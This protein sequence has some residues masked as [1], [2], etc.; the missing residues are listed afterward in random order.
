MEISVLS[1]EER[2]QLK[3]NLILKQKLHKS[4]RL[5]KHKEKRKLSNNCE[6][7]NQSEEKKRR[8]IQSPSKE[9]VH[10]PLAQN[11]VEKKEEIPTMN[12]KQRRTLITLKKHQTWKNK[13]PTNYNNSH[14]NNDNKDPSNKR[15]SHELSKLQTKMQEKLKEGHFRYLNEKLYTS[16]SNEAFQ[17]FQKNPQLF[18]E[19]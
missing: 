4:N 2:A 13:A 12:I 17:F 14:N 7:Q 6:I 5:F 18:F 15:N 10:D 19:V 3:N 11:K 8:T 16:T 1:D 9:I